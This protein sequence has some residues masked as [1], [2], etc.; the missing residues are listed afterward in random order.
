MGDGHMAGVH[1]RDGRDGKN[2]KWGYIFRPNDG[3]PYHIGRHEKCT[4]Y[5]DP[6]DHWHLSSEWWETKE[7]VERFLKK[8]GVHEKYEF[9]PIKVW[10]ITDEDKVGNSGSSP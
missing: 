8:Y 2:L 6:K 9:Q 1:G 5:G 4:P 10:V 3:T 7:A